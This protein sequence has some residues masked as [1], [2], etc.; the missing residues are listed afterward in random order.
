MRG[1][2]SEEPSSPAELDA[3]ELAHAFQRALAALP[4]PVRDAFLLSRRDGLRY[5]EIATAL[6]IS[7]KT[8][9]ARM[10]R[11]LKE[12]REQLKDWLPS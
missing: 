6:G 2:V 3:R 8:V 1:A 9:E 10:G 4:E 12:L 11:A 7:V 5:A